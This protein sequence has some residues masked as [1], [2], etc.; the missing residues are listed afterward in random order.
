MAAEKAIEELQPTL[1][2]PIATKVSK[3]D[4]FYKAEDYHQDYE[5]NNPNNPYIINVSK[6][7]IQKVKKKFS[8]RLKEGY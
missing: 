7:K 4:I 1:S 3:L 2:K 8:D 5:K 6:P